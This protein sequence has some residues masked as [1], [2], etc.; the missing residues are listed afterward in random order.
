MR[1]ILLYGLRTN[2]LEN[3]PQ[4]CLPAR[5]PTSHFRNNGA[6]GGT[7]RGEGGGA[8]RGE[9]RTAVVRGAGLRSRLEIKKAEAIPLWVEGPD[10]LHSNV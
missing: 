6:G 3:L 8:G 5:F 4:V 1:Y 10:V 7:G 2:A 9:A